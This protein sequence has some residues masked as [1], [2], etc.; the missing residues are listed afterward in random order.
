MT[1][2]YAYSFDQED[3]RGVFDTREQALQAGLTAVRDRSDMPEG[4]FVGQ[5]AA[6]AIEASGHAECVVEAIR[7]HWNAN[8]GDRSF[9]AKVTEQ[10]M[11]D[12]DH[13]LTL[14]I[15][16]WLTKHHLLPR[17]TEVRGVSHHPVPT[18]HHVSAPEGERETSVIGEA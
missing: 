10:Q 11:A 1:G 8:E 14:T 4:V 5:W 12:L 15:R 18:V 13:H 2:K 3:Y 17:P 6:P 9:L 7:D 16:N